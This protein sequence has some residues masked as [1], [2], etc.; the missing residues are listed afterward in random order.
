[1]SF[2]GIFLSFFM[3][4]LLNNN[5]FFRDLKI[6]KIFLIFI[7]FLFPFFYHAGFFNA[8][9]NDIFLSL[10]K[11]SYTVNT[12]I[13][14]KGFLEL[15]GP[16]GFYKL[17]FLLSSF[18]KELTPSF[19]FVLIGVFFFYLVFLIA[20]FIIFHSLFLAFIYDYFSLVF[21]SF[22][23]ICFYIKFYK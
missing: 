14:D 9:Y 2:L 18:A 7:N 4:Y 11:F 5:S 1:M 21:I 3:F 22:L 19:M 17:F 23:M 12:K 10:Y 6:Y 8:V 20:L 13:I 15:L 16:F